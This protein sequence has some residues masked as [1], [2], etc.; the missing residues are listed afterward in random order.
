LQVDPLGGGLP[1]DGQP[2]RAEYFVKGTEPT[3]QSPLYQNKD[4]KDYWVF[5]EKD[6]VSVDGQNRWQQGIESWITE[7]QVIIYNPPTGSM[8][9]Q[10]QIL[11]ISQTF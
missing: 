3:S 4:G 6:P 2:A 5:V 11:N 9:Q 10:H 8:R 7:N 1:K